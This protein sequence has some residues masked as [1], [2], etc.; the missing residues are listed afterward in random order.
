MNHETRPFSNDF[1]KDISEEGERLRGQ[2]MTPA[3][4]NVQAIELKNGFAAPGYLN[5]QLVFFRFSYRPSDRA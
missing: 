4:L 3:R 2:S 1:V 5:A